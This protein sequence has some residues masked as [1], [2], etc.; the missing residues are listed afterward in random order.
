VF[1]GVFRAEEVEGVR[2]KESG[3]KQNFQSWDYF[4]QMPDYQDSHIIVCWIK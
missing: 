4:S 3:E 2:D 1:S